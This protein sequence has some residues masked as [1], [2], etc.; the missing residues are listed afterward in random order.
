MQTT[1]IINNQLLMKSNWDGCLS[2]VIVIWCSSLIGQITKYS[3][4]I[5]WYWVIS[6]VINELCQEVFASYLLVIL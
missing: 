2:L 5:T 6:V 1:Q 3:S 4:I